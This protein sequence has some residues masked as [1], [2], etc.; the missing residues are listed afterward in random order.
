MLRPVGATELSRSYALRSSSRTAVRPRR[1]GTVE[2]R[3][4]ASGQRG[5]VADNLREL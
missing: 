4:G 3:A 5:V 2:G 1:P